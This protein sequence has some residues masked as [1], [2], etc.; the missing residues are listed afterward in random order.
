M[1]TCLKFCMQDCIQKKGAAV[2][3]TRSH[4]PKPILLLGSLPFGS[5]REALET[6][7]G[8]L[9]DRISRVPDGETEGER[10]LW[11]LCQQSVLAN[12]PDLEPVPRQERDPD[13][14]APKGSGLQRKKRPPHY[15][16]RAGAVNKELSFGPLGYAQWASASYAIFKQ[17][18]A[19]GRIRSDCRFQVCLPTPLVLLAALVE[20]SSHAQIEP[21]YERRLN[22]E[23]KAVAAAIPPTE[24]A[25][26]W[27]V[28]HEFAI[29]EGLTQVYFIDERLHFDQEK[30]TVI[31]RLVR[32]GSY[33]PEG[34]E[35]GYHLCYGDY[36]HRHFVEPKDTSILVQTANALARRVARRIDWLHMPV[37]RDRSDEEY[38]L[39]LRDLKLQ[40]GT[41]LFLG[42]V[43]Y[44]DGIEG[45][46]RRMRTAAKFVP[47]FGVAAECG[48]GR[49]PP[50]QDIK[51]LLG[52][53]REAA[54][55]AL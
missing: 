29:L 38:Y 42:L 15:R 54:E 8:I 32:L 34:I 33:V 31:D 46:K 36:G 27:D 26:Q 2:A 6:V 18:K 41:D 35:L 44:T 43:H 53:H 19:Q 47:D 7:A 11:I 21:A 10:P 25:I 13:A 45:T 1:L 39:P 30:S 12:H 22:D 37:P 50:T 52:L 23:I 9:G 14:D 40:P 17:L 4:G 48:L 51:V 20:P 28:A 3:E 5:S 49:R 24:L 16:V 55:A